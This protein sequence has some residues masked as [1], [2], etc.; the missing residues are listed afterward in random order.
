MASEQAPPLPPDSGY[1]FVGMA[2]LHN[3]IY[4]AID[5]TSNPT[6]KQSGKVVLITGAGRGIGR[7]IALQYAH[8][9][10]STIILCA[11]TSSELDEVSSAIQKTNS[12]VRVRKEVLS[13]TDGPAI[14]KLAASVCDQEGRLDV[15][16]NNA[17]MS[18]SWAPLADTDLEAYWTVL[19]VNLKGP[20]LLLHAFLPLLAATAA[21]QAAHVNVV[22]VT[23]VGAV[24]VSPGGSAYGVSK[25][26]LQRMSEFVAAE[27]GGRGVNVVGLHPGSVETK[28]SSGVEEIKP[29]LIDTAE[30]CGGF[31]VWLT[32]QERAWLNGRYVS[33]TW[34][35]GVLESKREEIVDGDK[36]KIKLVV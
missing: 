31:V 35:V 33:A 13:V 21:A 19:E 34:D 7:A 28:L 27:Y 15:L 36:L 23:S 11:R 9:S 30:L 17:G 29:Y 14:K 25:L 8:A 20:L 12:S 1:D 6:L 22:N 32:S 3:D 4:P 2:N 16:V 5:A 18:C 24:I 10:A 26:A